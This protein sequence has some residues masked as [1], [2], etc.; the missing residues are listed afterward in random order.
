[1]SDAEDSLRI[2]IIDDKPSF[3]RIFAKRLQLKGFFVVYENTFQDGLKRLKFEKFHAV[4]VDIPFEDVSESQ[5]L[6]IFQKSNLFTKT[7]VFLFSSIDLSSDELSR[8][9][10]SGLFSYLKKP[11][12]F[13][14]IIK[15]LEESLCQIWDTFDP[16]D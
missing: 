1:M 10:T 14:V 6:D 11:V 8:W 3:V 5:V 13:D 4:F 7:S 12:K 2:L 16:C 15:K 9:T